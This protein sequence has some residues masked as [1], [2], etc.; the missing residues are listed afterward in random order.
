ME[1]ALTQFDECG[2]IVVS[3]DSNLLDCIREF[4]WKELFWQHRAAVNTQLQCF[5]FGHAV[6]EK[7]LQPY[8]GLTAHAV[9]FL[10]EAKFFQWTLSQQLEYLDITTASAFEND[11]YPSP[12]HFQPFPL[13]GM[14]DWDTDNSVEH[15]Y[16]NTDYFRTGRRKR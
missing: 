16:D 7:A 10:V 8:I 3:A 13:L 5:I 6:Y 12:T 1:N 2:A 15:Y 4:R 11:A 9:L 14:P